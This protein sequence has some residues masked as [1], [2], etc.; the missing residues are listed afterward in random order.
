[1]EE[2]QT[3]QTKG[4]A[5]AVG[6]LVDGTSKIA[7]GHAAATD[8]KINDLAARF[9]LAMRGEMFFGIDDTQRSENQRFRKAMFVAACAS[10]AADAKARAE[11]DGGHD[12]AAKVAEMLA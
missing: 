8:S 6:L 10:L 4:R 5:D 2:L 12:V 3:L 7:L 9:A 11:K 1:M